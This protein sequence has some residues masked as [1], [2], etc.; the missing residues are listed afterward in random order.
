M[1][2]TSLAERLLVEEHD[3]HEHEDVVTERRQQL[4][5]EESAFRFFPWPRKRLLLPQNRQRCEVEIFIRRRKFGLDPHIC[6]LLFFYLKI[7]LKK[8]ETP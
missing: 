4:V 7:F 5:N 2:R 6:Q 1:L 8:G 3:E